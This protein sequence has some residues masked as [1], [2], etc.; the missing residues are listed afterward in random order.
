VSPTASIFHGIVVGIL[1][2]LL[3]SFGW[4]WEADALTAGVLLVVPV[5]WAA[6]RP[7]R[8]SRPDGPSS[9]PPT[10]HRRIGIAVLALVVPSLL[11]VVTPGATGFIEVKDSAHQAVILAMLLISIASAQLVLVSGLLDWFYVRPHLRGGLG[12]VCATSLES[13]WRNVTR[14]WLLHRAA[15]TLGPIAGITAL[16]ALTANSWIRPIDETVAAAIAGVATIIAGY[17]ITRTAPVLA[18]AINPPIQVGDVIEIAEEFNVHEPGRL[19]EYFV[20]DVALEGVKLLLVDR[21]DLVGRSGQDAERT[22]DR[23]VDITDIAKLLRGRRPI[24]PCPGFCQKLTLHCACPHPW[25]PSK[26][27]GT[28]VAGEA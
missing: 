18:I 17:Y 3:R 9:V 13:K 7:A 12:T 20:V 21:G 24:Q 11:V 10:D 27:A 6:G 23:A 15:A 2:A 8:R 4:A 26:P 19:R 28:K 14:V 25:V 5:L 16:I 1:L 22:H